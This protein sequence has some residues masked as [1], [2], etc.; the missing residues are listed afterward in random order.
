[1]ENKVNST[2]EQAWKLEVIERV[3]H[4]PA[5]DYKESF[6]EKRRRW[7]LEKAQVECRHI[8]NFSF[9]PAEV[10]GNIENFVGVAQVPIGIV[11]PIK[12]QGEYANGVFY[13]PFATTEGAMVSTY[14]RGAIAMAKSGGARTLILKDE[15]HLEPV[16]LLE[17]LTQVRPF[18]NWLETHF[19]EIK[20][21]ADST[22][23]HGRLL[24][25]TP[26]V[27]GSRVVLDFAYQTEDAMGANMVNIA[28]EKVCHFIV[29]RQPIKNFL[30]RSNLTSEKK[31]SAY[32][33]LSAYGKQVIA[34]TI[35]PHEI[36]E[37]YL[38]STPE[39][40]SSAW[41]SW[42]IASLGSGA[43]GMNAHFANGLAAI[44]IACGQDA[45][46]VANGCV[47]LII[48]EQTP[49]G[50][51]YA[52]VKLSSL[53]VGTIGGGTGFGTQRECLE[54]LGCYGVGKAKKFAEIIAA[55]LLAGEIGI[56]AGIT[57]EEFLDPHKRAR[58]HT[59]ARAYEDAKK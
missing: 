8:S 45:A 29:K 4:H 43:I 24:T 41:R 50:D 54:L 10:K 12:L 37:R 23:A 30:L 33:L 34:E 36:V 46:H 20:A 49:T 47:G 53:L 32:H 26:Y 22:T 31:A 40:I 1:M 48:F 35:L 14:Q 57:S 55:T 7:L 44:F 42:A 2:G 28:T 11:G 13:V 51:L 59:V 15:Q 52:A 27:F 21:E 6:I 19:K 39:K 16:F 3:P 38:H 56:C 18:L 17:N 25:I 58:V 9:D 5:D